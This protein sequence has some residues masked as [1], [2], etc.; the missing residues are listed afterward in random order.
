[1]IARDLEI[2]PSPHKLV[3]GIFYSSEEEPEEFINPIV[4]GFSEDLV[5]YIL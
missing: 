1:M 4:S 5:S 3:I 2:D